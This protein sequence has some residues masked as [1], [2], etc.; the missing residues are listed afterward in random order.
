MESIPFRWLRCPMLE[1]SEKR[2]TGRLGGGASSPPSEADKGTG[3]TPESILDRFSGG[4]WSRKNSLCTD[5]WG[6]RSSPGI[7][8][9]KSGL[10]GMSSGVPTLGMGER[11]PGC[12]T[13]S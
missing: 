11:P 4:W 12:C 8:S 9:V 3:M 13:D 5:D 6:M 2:D 10:G 7:A 1:E